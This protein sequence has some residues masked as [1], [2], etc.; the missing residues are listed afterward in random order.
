MVDEEIYFLTK[1]GKFQAEW[2]EN[3][4]VYRR[5]HFLFLLQREIEETQEQI[6]KQQKKNSHNLK[7]P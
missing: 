4:P 3:I 6:D 7:R 2:L 5:R 1:H